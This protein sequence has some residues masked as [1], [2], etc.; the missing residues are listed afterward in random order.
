MTLLLATATRIS[1][2][3]ASR[4]TRAWIHRMTDWV[5]TRCVGCRQDGVVTRA[6]VST[7]T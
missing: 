3:A 4:Y 5:S 1:T 7:A 2:T 6:Y